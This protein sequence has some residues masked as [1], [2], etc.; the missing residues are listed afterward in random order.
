MIGSWMSLVTFCYIVWDYGGGG[1][2]ED[3]L[4]I[5]TSITDDSK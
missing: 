4:V 3:L 1:A 5:Q 2:E